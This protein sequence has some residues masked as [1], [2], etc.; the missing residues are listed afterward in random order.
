MISQH[1]YNC[2]HLIEAALAHEELY[3][4]GKLLNP[5]IRYVDLIA[6]TFG[7]NEDHRRGY[8]GHPEIELAMLRLYAHTNN[9]KHLDLCRYFLEERGNPKG[10][11]S[12]HYYDY[13]ARKRGEKPFERPNCFP[14]R[15]DY[16]LV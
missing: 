4:N 7:P 9:P 2:G 13:E 12:M 16:W 11:D 14:M 3:G 1:S 8:S 6:N 15:G 10:Q 5:I